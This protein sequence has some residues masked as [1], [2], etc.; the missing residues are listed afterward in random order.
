MARLETEYRRLET[1]DDDPVEERD[2]ML[3]VVHESG[4]ARWNHIEN[5]DEFFTRVYHYHQKHGYLCMMLAQVLELVQFLFIIFFSLFLVRCVNYEVLFQDGDVGDKKVT[6]P[7]V[8]RSSECLSDPHG[9]G[10]IVICLIIAG[11]FWLHRLLRVLYNAFHF[12]EI[13]AF[14]TKALKIS[15]KELVNLTWHDVLKRV[16]QVQ[17]EQ[18]MCIH[19]A[20][21]TE[22]DIYHRILRFKNYMVAMVNKSLLP[23]HHQ[24][25]FYGDIVFLT[26]GL[27]YNLE[28]ILFWGPWAPFRNYWHLK[29]EYK[30]SSK[31]EELAQQLSKHILWIGCANFILSPFIFLW[32]IL[33][34]FFSY[35][36]LIKRDPSTLGARK[37]S[38]YGRLYLR[39]F[40]ELDHEF[41]ARLNRG[42]KPAKKYLDAFTSNV[43]AI[44]CQNIAFFAG[45][46]LAVLIILTVYDEDVLTVEHV[47]TTM[48]LLG[49]A[50]TICRTFIPDENLIW[51]PETLMQSILAQIHYIPDSWKG[52]AHTYRVRDEFSQL[53]QYKAVYFLEELLSPLLTP[54]VLICK[55]RPRALDIVDFYRNFTVDVIGV[56]D[57]CS[58]AQMDIRTHGN[59]K[60]MTGGN[61]EAN[62]YNQAEDGKTELSLMHFTVTNP[63]WTPPQSSKLFISAL[64][65]QAQRDIKTCT[66]L[67][68][69]NNA[70]MT[71]LRSIT[72]IEGQNSILGS[73][74]VQHS[75]PPSLDPM[76][77]P[78]FQPPAP[79]T[80]PIAEGATSPRT[81]QQVVGGITSSEGPL[82]PE[83]S[84]L[85]TSLHSPDAFLSSMQGPGVMQQSILPPTNPIVTGG[86]AANVTTAD[87]NFSALYMH[88]LHDRSVTLPNTSVEMQS[89]Q[90]SQ[91]TQW[92]MEPP[93]PASDSDEDEHPP[94]NIPLVPVGPLVNTDLPNV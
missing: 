30:R 38:Q 80:S 28:M 79:L 75:N 88:Q 13:R 40:N 56:G 82:S 27:K 62:Q 64:K 60:W 50:V 23:L 68:A 41:Q 53:F 18:R 45:S 83:G 69:E 85:L 65:T 78:S 57:V 86:T 20:E 39:H 17:R 8:I 9:A 61:S 84:G 59:P 47:L 89:P 66:R 3:H 46:I 70:L 76:P 43:L 49:V 72:S 15:S 1:V 51:C 48:T 35:A 71:S 14:Y 91:S 54:F 2:V 90:M 44:L 22:L 4:R 67:E 21:L 52:E 24:L 33:Y 36:E 81:S 10:V 58:F 92:Q 12:W 19:K 5:L 42:Y 87:M 32:Q 93:A 74:A 29:E 26:N 6:I 77:T 94:Q 37:W 7:Q 31:R 63:K 55:L 25:P 34:S 11:M 73:I 16:Q